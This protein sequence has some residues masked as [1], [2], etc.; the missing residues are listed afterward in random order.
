MEGFDI[1]WIFICSKKGL[2]LYHFIDSF[3]WWWHF[4]HLIL[5]HK[6]LW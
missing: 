5:H 6:S 3:A 2:E 1:T 4:G